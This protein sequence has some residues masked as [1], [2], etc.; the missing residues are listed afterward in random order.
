MSNEN[1][2]SK[3]L[4]DSVATATPEQRTLMLYNGAL[5]FCNQAMAAL[6]KKEYMKVNKLIQRAEDIIRE[7]Q[8]T[9]NMKYE[10]SAQMMDMY[11]LIH[12]TLKRANFKKDPEILTLATDLIRT[13]RDT[14]KEAMKLSKVK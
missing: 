10:I 6:E 1:P 12:Q 5:K 9:L 11:E 8:L 14:W 4:V 2:Y 7:F 13:M 3:L